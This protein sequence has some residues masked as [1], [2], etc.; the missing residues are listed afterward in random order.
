MKQILPHLDNCRQS[1]LFI[2]FMAPLRVIKASVRPV[3]PSVSL[4]LKIPMLEP[5]AFLEYIPNI[6]DFTFGNVVHVG[7]IISLPKHIQA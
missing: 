2:H 1:N 7:F 6:F 3:C 4:W 5:E